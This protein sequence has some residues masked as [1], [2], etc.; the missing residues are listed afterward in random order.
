MVLAARTRQKGRIMGFEF[1]RSDKS[2]AFFKDHPNFWDAFEKLMNASNQCFGRVCH[3]NN[4]AEDIMFSLGQ[5]CRN[6]YLEIMFMGVHGFNVATTKLLRGLYERAV[7]H[8]YIIK[9]PEKVMKFIRFGAIQEYRVMKGALEAGIAEDA[10]N[11]RMP[12]EN[13]ITSITER[14]DKVKDE[15]KVKECG[16]CGMKAPMSWDKLSVEAMAKKA[17]DLYKALYLGGYAL[18]NLHV[19]ATLT[20]A[21]YLEGADETC[22]AGV[23]K[24]E[25]YSNMGQAAA[26]ML[27]VL[28]E[29]N[30][31]FKL[32]LDKELE[33]AEKAFAEEWFTELGEVAGRHS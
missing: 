31:L 16:V 6:D 30:A 22:A 33:A 25:A 26:I 8:A 19:H 12:P 3:H 20:S 10:F 32:G 1:G 13:S 2:D 17:G 24:Y 5:T 9:N 15:F 27:L 21:V 29:Q 4:Q 18:P 23:R 28:K 14:R 11:E 7:T